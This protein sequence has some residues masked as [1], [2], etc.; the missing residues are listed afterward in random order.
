MQ[1]NIIRAAP[2]ADRY[3]YERFLESLKPQSISS[4]KKPDSDVAA[5]PGIKYSKRK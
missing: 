2:N 3:E 1:A 4:E 5:I